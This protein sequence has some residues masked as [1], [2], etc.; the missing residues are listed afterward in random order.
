MTFYGYDAKRFPLPASF[1]EDMRIGR[2]IEEHRQRFL[3]AGEKNVYEAEVTGKMMHA[4]GGSEDY[5]A[6]GDWVVLYPQDDTHATIMELIPRRTVLRRRETGRRQGEQI[7]A[8]NVDTA[9]IVM[10]ADRDFNLNR[11]ERYLTIIYDGDVEPMIVLNK[12]DLL[13]EEEKTLNKDVLIAN[14]PDIPVFLTS[15]VSGE[16]IQELKS[17]LTEG[18]TFGFI[19]SSGVGKS[20]LINMFLEEAR[21]DVAH[22]SDKTAKGRHTTTYRELIVLQNGSLLIDTPGMREVGLSNV[23]DG[24]DLTFDEITELAASCRFRDCTHTTEPGC[25]V[26]KAVED[27]ELDSRRLENYLALRR[28]ADHY[29][30]DD[31]QKRLKNKAFAKMVKEMTEFRKSK[32]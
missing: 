14:Y 24:L 7:I 11:L 5:P 10:A 28:E 19:G 25:A 2:V 22:I 12:S 32:K 4:A 20:S 3:V 8:A 23:G 30:M 17:S 27:G 16:N 18:R 13:T 26:L 15:V 29:Q 1:S 9:F 6:V 31:Y 21:Q